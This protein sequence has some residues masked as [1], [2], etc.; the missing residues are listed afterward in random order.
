MCDLSFNPDQPQYMVWAVGGIGETAFVHFSRA[1]R[2]CS[3]MYI[4]RLLR[5]DE[6]K[7]ISSK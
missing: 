5:Y 1:D 6:S 4:H 7:N 3:D 2:E